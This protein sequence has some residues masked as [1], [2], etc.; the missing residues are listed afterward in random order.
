MSKDT[1]H[2]VSIKI[3]DKEYLIGCPEGTEAELFAS[4]DYLD[5]KMR[6]IRDSGKV[7]GLERV[8]VMTALNLSHELMIQKGTQRDKIEARIQ[9]LGDK[10]DNS[11]ANLAK[12]HPENL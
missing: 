12:K 2:K 4:A 10:I 7:L 8:A 3:M 11:M 6:E 9:K 1:G 5:K